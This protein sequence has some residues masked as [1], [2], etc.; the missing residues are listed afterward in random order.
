MLAPA[1]LNLYLH[2]VG[3]RADGFHLLDSLVAFADIGDEITV[4]P[5][6]SL[7]VAITGP[8]A[9]EL[10]A[11][12]PKQNLVWRA[13]EALARELGRPP[14]A[15]IILEKNLPIAS[16]I[17]GGSSDA[18][19]TLTSLAALWNAKLA[20]ERIAAIGATLGADVPVC[21]AGHAAFIGGVGE[22]VATAPALP[23]AYLVLV[24]PGRPLPTPDVYRSRQGPFGQPARFAYAPANVTELAAIL[25][26]RR[27]DLTDAARTIVPEIGDVLTALAA[28]DGALLARMSGSGATCFALFAD[29]TAASAAAARLHGIN[30]GWW[31]AKGRLVS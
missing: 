11:H 24:N 22:L 25:K 31:V 20:P 29:N 1:K 12:D 7:N 30:S 23:E 18:A 13:G 6:H 3:R 16:G 28:C 9:T 14:G 17:G 15:L 21:L 27:N 8:F 4:S 5:A 19:A 10:A 2:V 26:A